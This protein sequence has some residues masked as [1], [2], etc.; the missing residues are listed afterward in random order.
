[1][2]MAGQRPSRASRLV[3]VALVATAAAVLLL[4]VGA[5]V[6][7]T[8]RGGE[9]SAPPSTTVAAGKPP[10]S[11]PL[12][13]TASSNENGNSVD[14]TRLPEAWTR[15][16]DSVPA[17]LGTTVRYDNGLEISVT[18]LGTVTAKG[19]ELAQT[20]K[21]ELLLLTEV[22]VRNGT[23]AELVAPQF[24]VRVRLGATQYTTDNVITDDALSTQL[25]SSAI[26]T[27]D[28]RRIKVLANGLTA[29]ALYAWSLENGRADLRQVTVEIEPKLEIGTST[30]AAVFEGSV[31]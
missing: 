19:G 6:A 15:P 30:P 5:L 28:R 21:G 27:D 9:R 23:G 1:M 20:K 25:L 12:D 11:G 13:H 10:P 14:G 2:T 17:R 3:T 8:V 4:G 24:I 31:S 7:V 18:R 26:P 16:D 22:M 29:T